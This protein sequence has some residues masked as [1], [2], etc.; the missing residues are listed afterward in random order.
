MDVLN[1]ECQFAVEAVALPVATDYSGNV[2]V[3][4][5]S[6]IAFYVASCMHTG[7]R[8][9]WAMMLQKLLLVWSALPADTKET[10]IKLLTLLVYYTIV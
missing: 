9:L 10:G 5:A 7:I 4:F 3:K 6:C 8:S 1:C 2:S